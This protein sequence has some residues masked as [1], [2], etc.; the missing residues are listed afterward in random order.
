M[1]ATATAYVW[2]HSPYRNGALNVHAALADTA[3]DLNDNQ[4]WFSVTR[5]AAKARVG[6]STVMNT[7]ADMIK[8]GFLEVV[9]AQRG[10]A[11]PKVYRLLFPAD[12][13]VVYEDGT[14]PRTGLVQKPDQSKKRA[15]LVQLPD[16][17]PITNPK[18]P[19]SSLG[20]KKRPAPIDES[21][22]VTDE[23]RQWATDKGIRSDIDSQT[24]L[25]R[26]H[27]EAKGDSRVTWVPL[28][29]SWLIRA[30]GYAAVQTKPGQSKS[31]TARER[32]IARAE[33]SNR[34][35]LTR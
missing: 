13:P 29:R 35:E 1:S 6:R 18:E 34:M 3:N 10:S 8:D 24:E 23:M 32:I 15:R 4:I 22:A 5:L 19:N 2:K 17:S 26:N 27:Y 28:W 7:Q 11:S 9:R 14:G 20:A 16:S 31:T 12:A 21:F 25:F 33:Q 30:D